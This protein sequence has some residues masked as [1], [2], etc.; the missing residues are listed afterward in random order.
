MFL[1]LLKK[2]IYQQTIPKNI[3]ITQK[4][5]KTPTTIPKTIPLTIEPNNR[6]ENINLTNTPV[7]TSI[8]YSTNLIKAYRLEDEEKKGKIFIL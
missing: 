7:K 2:Q 4:E 8:I 6:Q 1:L 5:T 3:S